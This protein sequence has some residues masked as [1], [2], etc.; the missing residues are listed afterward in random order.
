M[1]SSLST[2]DTS[3]LSTDEIKKKY[4]QVL[5]SRENQIKDLSVMIGAY[6]EK[7]SDVSKLKTQLSDRMILLEEENAKLS[8]KVSKLVKIIN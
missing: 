2:Y 3:K 5:A 7:V 1:R 4:D 8:M 6:N